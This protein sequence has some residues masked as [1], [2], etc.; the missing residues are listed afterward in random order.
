MD[1]SHGFWSMFIALNWV[2]LFLSNSCTRKNTTNM[3]TLVRFCI[4]FWRWFDLERISFCCLE[5]P[6]FFVAKSCWN[7]WNETGRIRWHL[8]VFFAK[9]WHAHTQM[10]D[11]DMCKLST[12]VIILC[13]SD[14]QAI[15]VQVCWCKTWRICFSEVIE[16]SPEKYLICQWLDFPSKIILTFLNTNKNM[17]TLEHL[18]K[19]LFTLNFEPEIIQENH[20][21]G[22]DDSTM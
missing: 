6:R 17:W 10:Q 21:F 2:T 22:Q 7:F 1:D 19:D 13:K 3:P 15:M 14:N 8:Y 12:W 18:R 5:V 9:F 4:N 11:Q 16:H 20:Y